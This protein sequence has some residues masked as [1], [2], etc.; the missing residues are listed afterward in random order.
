MSHILWFLFA[1]L[2]PTGSSLY[3]MSRTDSFWR[4]AATFIVSA[5]FVV[6]VAALYAMHFV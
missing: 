2:V 4:C 1:Y 6:I 5:A 3:V